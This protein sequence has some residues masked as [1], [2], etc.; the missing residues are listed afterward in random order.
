MKTVISGILAGISISIGGTVFLLCDSKVTGAIFFSVGLFSV[1]VFGFSL[2]TGRVCYVFDND[3]S[4]AVKL[5][6]IWAGNLIG[7]LVVGFLEMQTRLAPQLVEKAGD[8]SR[9]KL[10]QGL[11]SA[12]VLSVFCDIMIYIAVEGYKSIPHEIG[13]YLAIFFGVTVFVICGFEH[14]V[15][16]M[17]YFTVGKA[18]SGEA[19]LYL[20]IMTAGNA[21]GGVL[22]PLL[23]KAEAAN[24]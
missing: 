22:I 3:R 14:C 13:K 1:C 11:L 12:F 9:T 2:F 4:Y 20:L 18:W 21:A 5:P 6:L 17:Y 7:S 19:V 10:S 15:A 16:N 8:I 24:L 23:R